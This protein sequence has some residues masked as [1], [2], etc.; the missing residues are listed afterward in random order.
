MAASTPYLIHSPATS[1]SW[2]KGGVE[3]LLGVLLSTFSTFVMPAFT[4]RTMVIPETGPAQNGLQ[5]G[6]GREANQKAEFFRASLPVDPQVGLLAER[7]RR[8]PHVGRSSHPI[9]SFCGVNAGI[10]LDAQSLDD[11][12]A[13]IGSLA[14]AAGW[15][16][17]L[18]TGQAN[19]VSL[20]WAERLAGRRQ[21]VRWAL[22]PKGVVE[23]S[24]FPGCSMGFPAIEP[25]LTDI[26]RQGKLGELPLE[27]YPLAELV[28]I[29]RRK[30]ETDPLALLCD[31]LDCWCCAAVR[32]TSGFI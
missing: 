6:S 4:Y 11:P 13:L 30:I 29:T 9:L 14:E 12:L 31:R 1:Y 24:R 28:E 21:F 3:T 2:L 16:I 15:V 8:S 10:F 5:Y 25:F 26:V 23:C 17:L 20:H 32:Q 18:G 22:T 27:A 19:N 7:L